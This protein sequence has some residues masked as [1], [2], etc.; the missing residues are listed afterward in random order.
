MD[1]EDSLD[2]FAGSLKFTDYLEQRK[3]ETVN[4]IFSAVDEK[5][6]LLETLRSYSKLDLDE[7]RKF[8]NLS[9]LSTL[10]K[11]KLSSAMEKEIKEMLPNIISRLTERE[12]RII[13]RL[14]KNG[15]TLSYSIEIRDE[16]L[17]MKKLGFIGFFTA[18]SGQR[19][20]YLPD[21]TLQIIRDTC[22][23]LEVVSSIHLN[24]KINKLIRGL[25]YH[26]GAIDYKNLSEYLDKYFKEPISK[27]EILS[28]LVENSRKEYGI[29]FDG[30]Y[31][32]HDEV[33]DP[34]EVEKEQNMRPDLNFLDLTE[35]QVLSSCTESYKDQALFDRRLSSFLTD[36]F[37]IDRKA[38]EEYVDEL[39]MD[40]RSGVSFSEAIKELSENFDLADMSTL[41]SIIE[42]AKDVY[43][44]T[45]QWA[46]KGN[47]PL[48]A[49]TFNPSD[50]SSSQSEDVEAFP[51]KTGRNHPCPCG[52]GKKYKHC[53]LKR[54]L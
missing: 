8:L 25:L 20:L 5:V 48:K 11:Q 50:Q 45:G 49:H 35:T 26:Y 27:Y 44:N 10:S 29:K 21:D 30:T 18:P 3:N 54:N 34:Y 31:L 36:N 42:L 47:S 2:N 4:R 16:L 38:A 46:L 41:R 14:V 17:Y 19:F 43:N 33:F 51:F 28:F 13:K 53:C 15:G 39:K 1:D 6:S 32:Y 24:E 37:S 23:N 7:I 9:G 52:S 40:F 12:Y 22:S